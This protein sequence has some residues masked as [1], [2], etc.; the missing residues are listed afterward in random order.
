MEGPFS[1]GF[2][3]LT[4]AKDAAEIEGTPYAVGLHLAQAVL[5]ADAASSSSG[6]LVHEGLDV[7]QN[8][9]VI[10]L[11]GDIEVQIAVPQVAV[12]ALEFL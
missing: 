12:P 1:L 2:S 5:C 8:L 6:P 3:M 4:N 11:A 9:L 7:P 10:L